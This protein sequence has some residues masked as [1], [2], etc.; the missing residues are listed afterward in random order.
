[1]LCLFL[2]AEG[3]DY[4]ARIVAPE[5]CA[6]QAIVLLEPDDVTDK[7]LKIAVISQGRWTRVRWAPARSPRWPAPAKRD[8]PS[9]LDHDD[10]EHQ[11]SGIHGGSVGL[12]R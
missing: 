4:D 7:L 8:Q 3:A 11:R 10:D 1:V 12:S 5:R 9:N 6:P 2:R